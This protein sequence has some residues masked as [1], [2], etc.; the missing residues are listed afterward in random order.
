MCTDVTWCIE[1]FGG[2]VELR[3]RIEVWFGEK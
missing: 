2:G 3:A 1:N